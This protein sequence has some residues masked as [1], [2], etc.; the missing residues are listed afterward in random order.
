MAH[1]KIL[2]LGFK[3]LVVDGYPEYQAWVDPSFWP[4]EQLKEDSLTRE[5]EAVGQAAAVA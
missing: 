5:T 1:T 3:A 4:D 2:D